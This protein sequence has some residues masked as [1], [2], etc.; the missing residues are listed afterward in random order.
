MAE[1][2]FL[3]GAGDIEGVSEAIE[4]FGSEIGELV[5]DAGFSEFA[6]LS[7]DIEGLGDFVEDFGFIEIGAEVDGALL[8]VFFVF[9]K[10]FAD[11]LEAGVELANLVIVAGLVG[12]GE[13]ELYGGKDGAEEFDG[14]AFDSADGGEV[15]GI[16][17]G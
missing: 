13:L 9:A 14:F 11:F 8:G 17:D 10:G 1:D 2:V 6:K 12:L 16:G 7:E 15:E 4:N 3:G 5:A